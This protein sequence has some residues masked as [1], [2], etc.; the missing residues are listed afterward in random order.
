[1]P[2]AIA[3]S[4]PPPVKTNWPFLPL[5][6]A[7]PVSWHDGSTPPA[8]MYA[9]FSSSRATKRSLAEASG[10]SRMAA[11]C[12]EVAGPQQ[13]GD[14]AHRLAGQQ[15][16][17]LGVDL[18]ERSPAG[19]EGRDAV[20]RQQPVGRVVGPEGQQVL[21]GEVGHPTMLAT[22]SRQDNLAALPPG[23]QDSRGLG[24]APFGLTTRQI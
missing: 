20:G 6:M 23:R 3:A 22:C 7:V 14:V 11:S 21:V 17:G 13:V 9:F 4:S 5:T 8:A 24:C 19:L 2:R 10:S 12:A 1:M 15:R 16:Q 18:Q